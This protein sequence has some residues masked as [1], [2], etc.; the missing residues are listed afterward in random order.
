LNKRLGLSHGKVRPLFG[1][2][3]GFAVSRSTSARSCQRTARR[4]REVYEQ[5]RHDIRG[6]PEVVPGRKVWGGNRTW[7]GAEAQQI[8]MSVPQTCVQ[9]GLSPIRFLHDQLTSP[10]PLLPRLQRG[11]QLHR[12]TFGC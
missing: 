8:L 1:G 3:F 6:S 12:R 7:L 9:R 4:C 5:I 10:D 11:K 2:L